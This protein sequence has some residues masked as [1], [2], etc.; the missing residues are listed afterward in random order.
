MDG[1]TL[2]EFINTEEKYNKMIHEVNT[3]HKF[4]EIFLKLLSDDKLEMSNILT[5]MRIIERDVILVHNLT[6]ATA[7]L[8]MTETFVDYMMLK[9][10]EKKEEEDQKKPKKPQKPK[11][12]QKADFKK[13]K[14]MKPAV[15]QGIWECDC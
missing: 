7:L 2:P 12:L 5:L 1:I 13:D 8:D 15:E 10:S 6:E 4:E 11:K 3:L 9:Q 14:K